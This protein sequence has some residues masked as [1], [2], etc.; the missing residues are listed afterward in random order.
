MEV[1]EVLKLLSGERGSVFLENALW[2]ILFT[3]TIAVMV[4][5]LASATGT[6]FGELTDR[7]GQ[8]GTP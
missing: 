6:K 7:I 5:G 8:V 4:T 2:I 1:C 3:L